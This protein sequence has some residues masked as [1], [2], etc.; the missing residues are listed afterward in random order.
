GDAEYDSALSIRISEHGRVGDEWLRA[1][2][3]LRLCTSYLRAF[4]T[5]LESEIPPDHRLPRRVVLFRGKSP[6]SLQDRVA[7]DAKGWA[8]IDVDPTDD[9]PLAGD[10]EAAQTLGLCICRRRGGEHH[11]Q[12]TLSK[13]DHSCRPPRSRFEPAPFLLPPASARMGIPVVSG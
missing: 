9:L 12:R 1:E 6:H 4:I 5:K 13:R 8:R 11:C 3:A 2:N 7:G 10:G